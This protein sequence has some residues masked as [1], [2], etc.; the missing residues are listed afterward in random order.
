[1][2]DSEAQMSLRPLGNAWAHPWAT[3][4]HVADDLEQACIEHHFFEIPTSKNNVRDTAVP[5]AESSRFT[6]LLTD[7][8]NT[9]A[10]QHDSS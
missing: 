5:H 3:E 1:M 2:A 8:E 9:G 6:S 4:I 7:N 10:S